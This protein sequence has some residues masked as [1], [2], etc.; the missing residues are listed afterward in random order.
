MAFP[1]ETATVLLTRMAKRLR[2]ETSNPLYRSPSELTRPPLSEL[3]KI[4]LTR[5]LHFLFTEPVVFA[6]S[7]YVG[8]VWGILYGIVEAIPYVFETLYGFG[9]VQLGLVYISLMLV[10]FLYILNAPSLSFSCD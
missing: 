7:L 2:K 8:F 9:V 4:S 5:P 1:L 10:C 3:I 6:F